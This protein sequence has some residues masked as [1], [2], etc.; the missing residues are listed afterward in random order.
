MTA[1]AEAAQ[2]SV[3]RDL[4]RG[5]SV[6]LPFADL[7]GPGV[8]RGI[9]LNDEYQPGA[10]AGTDGRC[11]Q[12]M[13][14]GDGTWC[15]QPVPWMSV[16]WPDRVGVL[17]AR[18]IRRIGLSTDEGVLGDGRSHSRTVAYVEVDF[19]ADDSKGVSEFLTEA[20]RTCA[21]GVASRVH[22]L[23]AVVGHV[24]SGTNRSGDVTSVAFLG[25]TRVAW[26][27]LDGRA[28]TK[29]EEDRALTALARHLS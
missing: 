20:F 15:G 17:G 25:Q 14:D 7:F 6:K 9:D 11:Q 27:V 1:V 16:D 13:P 18:Q 26:V 10:G 22:G 2:C 19:W 21:G 4:G 23:P 5:G 8:R 24:P 12:E 28:W 29:A 3:H